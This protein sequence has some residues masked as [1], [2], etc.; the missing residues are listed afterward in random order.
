M[1]AG[2]KFELAYNGGA[3]QHVSHEDSPLCVGEGGRARA[4]SSQFNYQAKLERMGQTKN[5]RMSRKRSIP[6]IIFLFY[7]E[8]GIATGLDL[9]NQVFFCFWFWF[10]F[11]FRFCFFFVFLFFWGGFKSMPKDTLQTRVYVFAC[12]R[13]NRIYG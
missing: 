7:I 5:T 3:V 9:R 2:V 13:A 10:C 4:I 11:V 1:I 8:R 6:P 12:V